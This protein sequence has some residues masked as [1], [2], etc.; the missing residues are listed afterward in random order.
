MKDELKMLF[1]SRIGWFLAGVF[2]THGDM[3]S[4][5]KGLMTFAGV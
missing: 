2:L 5:I 4:V 3:N 1:E